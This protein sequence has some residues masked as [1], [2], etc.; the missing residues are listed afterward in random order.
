MKDSTME[1]RSFLKYAATATVASGLLG[2]PIAARAGQKG[3]KMSKALQ[4]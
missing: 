3:T 4:F 1:R 2:R